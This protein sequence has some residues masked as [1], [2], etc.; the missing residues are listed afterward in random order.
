MKPTNFQLFAMGIALALSGA[1]TAETG[2]GYSI[3]VEG[4]QKTMADGTFGWGK[5]QLMIY[6]F[7]TINQKALHQRWLPVVRLYG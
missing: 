2:V 6:G 4:E 3:N 5:P 7:Q 1:A